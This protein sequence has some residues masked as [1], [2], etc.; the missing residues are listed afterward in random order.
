M[1]RR[2]CPSHPSNANRSLWIRARAVALAVALAAAAIPIPARAQSTSQLSADSAT[3]PTVKPDSKKA[4][5]AYQEG[6][7]AEKVQN[8]DAA[9]SAYS[10]AVNYAPNVRE[11]QLRRAVAKS[12]LVQTKVDAAERDAISGRL[13]D[14]RRELLG[15]NYLDPSNTVVRERLIEM[16]MADPRNVSQI[17]AP[18]VGGE[19][20]LAYQSGTHSFDFRGTTQ[21]AYDEIGRQFGVEAAFDVDLR[22]RT[23]HFKVDDVDFQ[24][25]TRLLGDMTGTFWRPLTRKLFFVA[26][27]TPQK[28]KDYD[29]SVIRTVLL[30]A[31]ESTDQMTEMLRMIREI[32]GITR[33]DLDVRSRT[34]TLRASPRAIA[35]AADL[36]DNLEQPTGEMILEMEILDVDKTNAT[37]LGITPPQH[38]QI[39]SVSSQQ[40]QEAEQSQ[41][42]LMNVVE[43]IF[44][45]AAIPPLIAFG[46]GLTTY[47]ATLPGATADFAQMLTVVR[48]GRR[49]LL[50]AHDGQPATFFVGDRIPVSLSTFSPSLISGTTNPG[51]GIV[52]PIVN[53][54]VGNNP[55][56]IVAADFHDTLTTSSTDLAVA[57][58]LDNTVSILPGNGDGTFGAQTLVTLP[59]GFNPTS[60]ATASFTSSGHKDLVL[61]GTNATTNAGSALILLGNGDGTFT[62]PTPSLIPVGNGPVSVIVNDFNGDGFEDL[63]VANQGDNTVAIVPGN[64]DGTFNAPIV[65]KLIGGFTPT[66]LTSAEFT[67]SG[68][69][70]LAVTEK[71]SV[72]NNNGQVQVFLGN[73]DGTFIQ[74]SFS[75]YLVGNTPAFVTTGDFN[76]DGILDLVVANSG[77]QSTATNGNIVPGNGVS[78]LLGN[79]STSN[80]LV[81]NGTFGA[82]SPF[83]AGTTPTSIAVADFDGDG[84]A[85][86][87]VSDQGDNAVTVLLNS[88]TGLF[89]A[90]PELPVAT[91]PVS[92]VSADFNGDDKPDT[93]VADNGSAQ[94][95]VIINSTTLFGPGE[96]PLTPF[97]GVQYLDIGLKT[98]AT[99]R[100]HPNGDV[101]LKLSFE[102]SRLTTQ[103]FNAIPVISNQ[104]IEQTVR[105]KNNETAVLAGF[106]QVQL[107]NAI[108]GNPGLGEVP[109]IGLLDSNE[110]P[111]QNLSE[112]LIMVTPRMVRLAPRKDRVIYAGKGSPEGA[113]GTG[114]FI[115]TPQPG[116]PAP[117]QV[118][119]EPPPV[120]PPPVQPQPGPA[121]AQP[122]PVNPGVPPQGQAPQQ[123]PPEQTPPPANE[124]PPQ[125]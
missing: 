109:G 21:S 12:R 84:S 54:T 88:G 99:P 5:A 27:D 4:K 91:G 26:E 59:A 41:E 81:G 50:R 51:T 37:Q 86:I 98:K 74:G 67:N 18:D 32:A 75:P 52:T 14:A 70:D 1:R 77:A 93:A 24:T 20:H 36:I 95:T 28:R 110:N 43:Q 125:D 57:N 62:Q 111:T 118:P 101:T 49:V 65:T 80:T 22:S 30:P 53:Y 116:R 114:A 46:G 63:A 38:A 64:G 124:E 11:Y 105:L 121:P 117:D 35:V 6:I 120:Q 55:V 107:S 16:A 108:T 15:A 97:P 34:I 40:I 58:Q 113:S 56:S 69:P 17:A 68:H 102:I 73:G 78:V 33:S 42:G 9:Y 19:I 13:D 71:P 29:A 47:L 92:I 61:T 2:I 31:S 39:Y 96:N 72:A 89:A 79:A 82:Q 10:D 7:Q 112:M 66:S 103:S 115:G 87:A 44:G 119:A 90:L 8:W 106:Q 45:G 100:I 104:S 76:G 60:M 94:A 48:D 25:A 83:L 122:S 23:V 123:Q 85:D 3:A